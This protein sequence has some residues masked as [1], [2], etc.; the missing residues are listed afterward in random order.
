MDPKAKKCIFLGYGTLRN[1]YHLYHRKTSSIIY[2]RDVV[3]SESSRR[4]ESEE[5]KRLIQVENFTEE[6][7]KAPE[8]AASEPEGES[9]KV[10]PQAEVE[11]EESAKVPVLR[12]T[13]TRETRKPD[14]YGVWVNTANELEKDP[15]TVKEALNCPEK[16]QWKAAMQREMDSIYSNDVWNLVERD[17][18]PQ[19][20]EAQGIPNVQRQVGQPVPPAIPPTC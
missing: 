6:E 2:N 14:Y 10:E 8:R 13:S 20:M 15:L 16:E 7:P 11:M 12:R 18:L 17:W 5:N 19:P 1:G 9:N 3:F 4:Y